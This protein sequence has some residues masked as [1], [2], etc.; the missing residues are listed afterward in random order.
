MAAAVR[1]P[2]R[3][4]RPHA[5]GPTQTGGRE[6]VIPRR[7][8]LPPFKGLSPVVFYLAR[9]EDTAQDS[10]RSVRPKDAMSVLLP[11]LPAGGGGSVA[12]SGLD[13]SRGARAHVT[14]CIPTPHLAS[15]CP[16][17]FHVFLP[18]VNL[19]VWFVSFEAHF[20]YVDFVWKFMFTAPALSPPPRPRCVPHHAC[21]AHA[22]PRGS[23]LCLQS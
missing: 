10:S 13:W 8:F 7:C 3:D 11:L 2:V 1:Q 14:S 18:N 15:V 12:Q 16:F 20:C 4:A 5:P 21:W 6:A 22:L 23:C 19:S 17:V 9:P